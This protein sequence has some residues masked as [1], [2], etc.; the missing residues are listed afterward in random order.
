MK[1]ALIG[2]IVTLALMT[3]LVIG[4]LINN[5]DDTN[6]QST[7]TTS[8]VTKSNTSDTDTSVE[9]LV[10]YTLP[11]GW[12]KA[13]CP[14]TTG[15][16]YLQPNEAPKIDCGNT[17]ELR[18]KLS[19]IGQNVTEC[20]Q[21]QDVQEVKKHV[22]IS[23]YINDLRSLRAL[24]EYLPSSEFGRDTT[25]QTYYIDS[26]SG[27]IKAEYLHAGNNQYQSGFDELTGS[28]RAK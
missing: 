10:S 15:S 12:E 21:I 19:V 28:I 3:G 8:D 5:Q 16:V 23:L 2:I 11:D 20:S 22:C 6:P 13:V 25:I 1:N 4:L 17:P 26:G 9:S 7:D 24:T 27:I 18:I 14:S